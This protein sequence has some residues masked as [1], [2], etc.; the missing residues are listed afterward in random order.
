ME[1]PLLWS[2]FVWPL[3]NEKE[4]GCVYRILKQHGVYVKQL[5]FLDDAPEPKQFWKMLRWCSNVVELKLT[6]TVSHQDHLPEVIAHMPQLEKLDVQWNGRF[7]SL[8]TYT[9]NLKELT[10]RIQVLKD[11][12]EPSVLAS[13]YRWITEGFKVQ[14]L[15]IVYHRVHV[16]VKELLHEWA[17]YNFHVPDGRIGYL[18]LYSS[19]KDLYYSVPV[20]KL[21]FAKAATLPYLDANKSGLVGLGQNNLIL[22]TI[23]SHS[24]TVGHKGLTQEHNNAFQSISL[25]FVTDFNISNKL[26]TSEHLES[27]AV[28]CPNLRRLDL[29]NSNNCL[30]SLKG[31][32]SIANCCV[33]LNRLNL[34]GIS[35][36]EVDHVKLWKVLSD[37]KLT[38]LAMELC[39]A[40]VLP[41]DVQ[42]CTYLYHKCSSLEA[43]H[44]K[45]SMH[46]Q[47]LYGCTLCTRFLDDYLL[48]L[49]QFPSLNSC[50]V[51]KIPC[52][53]VNAIKIILTDCQHLK[54]F[55]FS[56]HPGDTA[57]Y[58][59]GLH[60]IQ[61]SLS[62]PF[63]CNL[64][65][66]YVVI[67][68]FNIPD[69]FMSRVSAHGGLVHVSLDVSQITYEG[70]IT[71]IENSPELLTLHVCGVI[72]VNEEDAPDSV[73]EFKATMRKRF[74]SRK[75]FTAA[76]SIEMHR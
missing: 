7:P 8:L 75:L 48:P 51:E 21:Q 23:C 67:S 38:H 47:Y 41:D 13:V 16:Y 58:R 33:H 25:H 18:K 26:F 64:Q 28:L 20:F 62:F 53:C 24:S 6:A 43:L 15:N 72:I 65:Q 39:N 69:V 63:T 37:M 46:S 60:N 12:L 61:P 11:T 3:Y 36:A 57:N 56:L 30:T 17:L 70:I 5:S 59:Y 55:K 71:L 52:H 2:V 4:G 34:L 74:P 66:L 50:F 22:P 49:S 27:L 31:L 44:L 40:T 35:A 76:G 1:T 29:Q 68:I 32:R 9:N 14:T 73:D 45:R 42:T 19:D 10:V 54:D